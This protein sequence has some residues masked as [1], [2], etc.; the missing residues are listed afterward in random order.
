[1]GNYSIPKPSFR[2]A[3]SIDWFSHES[4]LFLPPTQHPEACRHNLGNDVSGEMD[5]RERLGVAN[6]RWILVHKSRK[7]KAVIF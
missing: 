6:V 2:H 4:H 1:M 3:P 5:I 7:N